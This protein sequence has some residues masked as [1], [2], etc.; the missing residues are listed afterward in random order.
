MVAVIIFKTKN[1]LAIPRFDYARVFSSYGDTRRYDSIELKFQIKGHTR[2]SCDRGFG[3][4]RNV[5]ARNSY[6]SA[7]EVAES[8]STIRNIVGEIVPLSTFRDWKV[9]QNYYKTLDG[10]SGYQL[11][12]FSSSRKGYVGHR[13]D[14]T[15]PIVWEKLRKDKFPLPS[16]LVTHYTFV[17]KGA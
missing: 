14:P 13:V 1:V 10:I 2:N 9:L 8:M 11:F 7:A 6:Y 12:S 3:T 15:D 17:G 16:N 5:F 4:F